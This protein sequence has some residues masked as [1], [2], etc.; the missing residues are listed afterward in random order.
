LYDEA[1]RKFILS[2][3]GILLEFDKDPLT[4]DKQLACLDR[5]HSKKIYHEWDNDLP[6][7][8]GGIPVLDQ[9]LEFQ[10]PSTTSSSSDSPLENEDSLNDSSDSE[11]SVPTLEEYVLQ[12][13]SKTLETEQSLQQPICR[14]SRIKTF[15]RKYDEFVTPIAHADEFGKTETRCFARQ[16]EEN[17]GCCRLIHTWETWNKSSIHS[18]C[19]WGQV[20]VKVLSPNPQLLRLGQLL[21]KPRGVVPNKYT[22]AFKLST[23]MKSRSLLYFQTI[24]HKLNK[25]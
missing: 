23:K 15:P 11:E 21:A 4:V 1:T 12:S 7:L 24:N 13:I 19:P 3:D 20:R 9:S 17:A 2:R 10:F 14:S 16:S 22:K 18:V 8:E 6:N 25:T 5:F